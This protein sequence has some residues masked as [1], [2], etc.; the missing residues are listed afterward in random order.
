[1][2]ED[3][4]RESEYV[5]RLALDDADGDLVTFRYLDA[6]APKADDTR[7]E[8]NRPSWEA[9]G[10]PSHLKVRIAPDRQQP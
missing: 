1:M 5:Y 2:P 10:R 8:L 4:Q 6:A 7:L 9:L 3:P